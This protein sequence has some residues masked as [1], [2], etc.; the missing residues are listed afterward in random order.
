MNDKELARK[1][2]HLGVDFDLSGKTAEWQIVHEA[3]IRLDELATL[4]EL[5][6]LTDRL[7]F[8]ER[9]CMEWR[10]TTAII[11]RHIEIGTTDALRRAISLY[12]QT[13]EA[14]STE[15]RQLLA[16]DPDQ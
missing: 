2:R 5:V 16:Q 4:R 10:T 14:Y 12:G 6:A 7:S 13:R 11:N 8:W 15:L 3:A 1:L 9:W